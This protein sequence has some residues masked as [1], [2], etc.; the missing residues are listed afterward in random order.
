MPQVKQTPRECSSGSC[1]NA[2]CLYIFYLYYP[3]VTMCEGTLG[4]PVG[5][6]WSANNLGPQ[7][8]CAI[9]RVNVHTHSPIEASIWKHSLHK[10]S[11][12]LINKRLFVR[13]YKVVNPC[14]KRADSEEIKSAREVQD[15]RAGDVGVFP[16]PPRDSVP[17]LYSAVGDAIYK[18]Q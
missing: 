16:K 4:A 6:V 15:R 9:T 14:R 5:A 7:I 11:S 10:C 2:L 3:C 18:L 1:T 8:T 17:L 12:L 13:C